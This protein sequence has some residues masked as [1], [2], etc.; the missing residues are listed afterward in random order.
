MA[1]MLAK[2]LSCP[3]KIAME[4]PES[5]AN[6]R[7]IETLDLRNNNLEE[8]PIEILSNM[9]SLMQLNILGNP[10]SEKTKK[11]LRAFLRLM[12]RR[13]IVDDPEVASYF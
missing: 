8:I 4:L 3:S 1:N 9:D 12:P 5:M 6:L 13:V 11:K 2:L 7:R 10:L